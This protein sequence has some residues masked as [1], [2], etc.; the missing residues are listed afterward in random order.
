MTESTGLKASKHIIPTP[1]SA[2]HGI[3]QTNRLLVIARG[4]D[5]KLFVN[6]SFVGEFQDDT[7]PAAAYVGVS[8]AYNPGG[9]ASFSNLDIY[10][11]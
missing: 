9:E 10:P 2:I 3:G 6:G 4:D 1:S 8:L 11:D 7:L 5:F